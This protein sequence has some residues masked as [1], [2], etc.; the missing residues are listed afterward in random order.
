MFK[1]I[2]TSKRC[3]V[4]CDGGSKIHEFN[5]I[6]PHISSGDI[7]MAHD[8][9]HSKEIYKTDIQGKLWNWNE[10]TYADIAASVEAQN[11]EYYKRDVFSK[12]V[13]G[14]FIKRG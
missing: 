13:W 3:A 6:A 14:C 1:D 2:S 8:Y 5:V 7:I 11:L 10:I 12:A 9:A 4:L